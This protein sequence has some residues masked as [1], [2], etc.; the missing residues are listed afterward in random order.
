MSSALAA[1]GRSS[2]D[3]PP[4]RDHASITSHAHGEKAGASV[5][6]LGVADPEEHD[7]RI[8]SEDLELERQTTPRGQ[9]LSLVADPDG[10]VVVFA[11]DL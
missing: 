3:E 7:Q 9:Q 4:A 5:V 8:V 10:S 6:T 1:T 2:G 11:Q